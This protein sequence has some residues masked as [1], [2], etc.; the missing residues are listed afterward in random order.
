VKW[1][2]L[3]N[4]VIHNPKLLMLSPG[5]R[6]YYIGLL[7]LK[8][9]GVLDRFTGEKLDRAIAT[10]LRLTIVEWEEAARRLE[11]EELIDEEYQ[12][13]GWDDRQYTHDSSAE[14][15]RNYRNR[16]KNKQCDVSDR[17]SDVT[18]TGSDTDTDTDTDKRVRQKRKRFVPP[19]LEEVSARCQ[20]MGYQV[21]PERFWNFYESQ[22]WKVGKNP[23]RDWHRALAG[24]QSRDGNK[25]S[26]KSEFLDD[27]TDTSWAH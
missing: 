27:L 18:V 11:A 6:W 3:Y 22:G 7:A 13:I 26:R 24:W 1:F 5:D 4:D 20:E 17:H 14:R 21:D 15:T 16:L 9:E 25:A 19:T 8:Q 12:P 10:Q 23:M 2:R